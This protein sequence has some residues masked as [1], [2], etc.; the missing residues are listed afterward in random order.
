MSEKKARK[1]LAGFAIISSLVLLPTI[2]YFLSL[3]NH[4][5]DFHTLTLKPPFSDQACTKIHT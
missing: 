4:S 1:Q 3:I 2:L 5:S